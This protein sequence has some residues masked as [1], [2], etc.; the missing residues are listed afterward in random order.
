MCVYHV[1]MATFV[2]ISRTCFPTAPSWL[3]LVNVL[4]VSLVATV[5][6]ADQ[7]VGHIRRDL[8]GAWL[9]EQTFAVVDCRRGTLSVVDVE[10]FA[11]AREWKLSELVGRDRC[12]LLDIAVHRDRQELYLID[13][14]NG[15][16]LVCRYRPGELEFVEPLPAGRG[17]SHISIA[18]QTMTTAVSARWDRS[19]SLFQLE[20]GIRQQAR[21]TLDYEPGLVAFSPNERWLLVLDAFAGFMSLIDVSTG[22]VL[23]EYE[24]MGMQLAG[25]AWLNDHDFVVT[26][27]LLHADA[28]STPENIAAGRVIENVMHEFSIQPNAVGQP[29][30][31]DKLVSELGVPSHG[32]AD[33]SGIVASTTGERFV[34]L[35]GVGEVALLNRYGVVVN[36]LPAGRRPV[37]LLLDDDRQVLYCLNAHADSVTRIDLKTQTVSGTLPLDSA[38][39]LT[40][41]ERGERL[42]FDARLSRFGWYSCHSCHVDGHTSGR[43]ADTFGDGTAGAPKRVLSLLGGRDNNPWG[44][45]GMKRTLHEQVAQSV[46]STMHGP[47]LSARDVNDLVAFLHTL[48]RPPAYRPP[49][50]EADREQI[51]YGEKV[52]Q[53]SGCARCHVPPLTFTSDINYDVGLSDEHGLQKFNPP[54]LRGVGFRRTLL[55]DAR[56][57]SLRGVLLEYGHQL[58][59]LPPKPELDA[60]LRYLESL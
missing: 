38:E 17:A 40:A 51:A 22:Q 5:C 28:A 14:H 24:L 16:V 19:V 60:L 44:W 46:K 35:S 36:R 43:L 2:S 52:F 29:M 55:H 18:P 58:D 1:C 45:N 11:V 57:D 8:S 21:I 23:S 27:Q 48:Q 53:Q 37:S 32:A 39:D 42:F 4:C 34:A 50:D 31:V 13:A 49:I 6:P 12:E 30:I 41:K 59:E 47:G 33:P 26:H 9:D 56:A 10:E 54:S 15:D 25:L 7:S 20:D 3:T